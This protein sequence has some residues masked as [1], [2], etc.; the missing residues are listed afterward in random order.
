MLGSPWCQRPSVDA[1]LR[2][3][4]GASRWRDTIELG[5]NE[6]VDVT[7]MLSSLVSGVT[8]IR[9]TS[10]LPIFGLLPLIAQARLTA[11]SRA[12]AINAYRQCGTHRW[13]RFR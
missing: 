2:R 10:D 3:T 12:W 5:T 11:V 1:G 4:D 7:Y 6:G 9:F 8:T 13:E